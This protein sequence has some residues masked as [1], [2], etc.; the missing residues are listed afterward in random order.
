MKTITT[1]G[2]AYVAKT[3]ITIERVCRACSRKIL[4]QTKR[5]KEIILAESSQALRMREHELRLALNEAEAL[6]WQTNYPHLL[7]PALATEKI[8]A[9]VNWNKRQQMVRQSN[10]TLVQT[11]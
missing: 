10:P 9:V 6:V 11:A 8:Q 7:F 4:A 3:R 2:E 5:V 1:N